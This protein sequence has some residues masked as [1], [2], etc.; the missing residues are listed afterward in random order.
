M[1]HKVTNFIQ[2][3]YN[4]KCI[5]NYQVTNKIKYLSN[6]QTEPKPTIPSQTDPASREPD[7]VTTEADWTDRKG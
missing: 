1:A 3:L 4:N 7:E 5:R 2:R 6:T